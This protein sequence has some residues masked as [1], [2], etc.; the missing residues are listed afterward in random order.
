MVAIVRWYDGREIPLDMV[1][2]PEEL[3]RIGGIPEDIDEETA[4]NAARR[5]LWKVYHDFNARK[6][7]DDIVID[8]HGE[9]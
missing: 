1:K 9:E 8:W 4:L 7:V 3:V 6:R 5:R 2:S